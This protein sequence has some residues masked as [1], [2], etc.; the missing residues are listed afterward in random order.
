MFI[1]FWRI[2]KFSFQDIFRN[3]WLSIVTILILTLTLLSVNLL[4]SVQAISSAAVETVKDKVDISL[5]LMPDAPEERVA[6]LKARIAVLENVKDVQYVSQAD[7]LQ[8]FQ[9]THQDDPGVIEALQELDQNPLTPSLVIAPKDT[10]KFDQLIT[11][12]NRINDSIIESRNFDDH[13]ILLSKI[14][15][16]TKKVSDAGF[17]VSIIFIFITL[18]VI[19]NTV[20]VAIYTHRNE[21][22]IMRLVGASN[23]FIKAPFLTSSLIYTL[24]AT[25]IVIIVFYGFLTLLHPYLQTFFVGYNFNIINYFTSNFWGI[26]GLQ[27]L[28]AAM[29]NILASL[30]AVSKYSKV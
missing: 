18:L 21:I 9:E 10:N 14:N 4:I 8:A 26:F 22:G 15:A 3:I 25:I 5:Y 6:S 24:I 7:A 30:L 11:D 28:A 20:R 2:L 12:L 1:S 23:W 17:L 27:F 29:V 19:F 13:K 16:I